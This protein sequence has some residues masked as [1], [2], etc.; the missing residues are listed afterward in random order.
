METEISDLDK[1]IEGLQNQLSNPAPI[2]PT[3]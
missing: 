3:K 1:H 2:S